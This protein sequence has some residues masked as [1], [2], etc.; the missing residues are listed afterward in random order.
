[1]VLVTDLCRQTQRQTNLCPRTDRQTKNR[2]TSV[3]KLCSQTVQSDKGIGGPLTKTLVDRQ[4]NIRTSTRKLCRLTNGHADLYPENLQKT[5]KQSAEIVTE[6]CVDRRRDKWTT[7]QKL[8]RQKRG[9]ANLCLKT[10][11]DRRKD[12]CT[13]DQNLCGQ[14]KE[15]ADLYP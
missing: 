3:L 6:N 5:K 12:G 7:D 14:T 10:Y 2:R 13:S 1:M 9:Q 8:R 4:R 11:V 15:Q